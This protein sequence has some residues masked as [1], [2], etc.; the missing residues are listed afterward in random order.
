MYVVGVCI[1][2]CM[3]VCMYAC[4]KSIY[5][6]VYGTFQKTN[7]LYE[8]YLHVHLPLMKHSCTSIWNLYF[9]KL[10]MAHFPVL[11][12]PISHWPTQSYEFGKPNF[13]IFP[14]LFGLT[15]QISR[16]NLEICKS[17]NLGLK[18][19]EIWKVSLKQSGNL[20]I[21]E[22]GNLEIELALY[23]AVEV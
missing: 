6:Y 16:M 20:E 22:S 10:E 9:P 19:L 23:V 21:C 8:T 4:T 7:I 11:A 2:V 18:N 17:G 12:S 14:D 1:Y 15:F 13:S 5:I 3:Y